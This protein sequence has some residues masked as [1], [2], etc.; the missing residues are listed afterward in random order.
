MQ[1]GRQE[2]GEPLLQELDG[3]DGASRKFKELLEG[4][5]VTEDSRFFFVKPYPT[6]SRASLGDGAIALIWN[7]KG[8]SS[9]EERLGGEEEALH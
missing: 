8:A 4:Q 2:D 5:G 6:F 7:G 1:V 9:E 3:E